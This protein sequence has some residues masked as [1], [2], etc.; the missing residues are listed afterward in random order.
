M[1]RVAGELGEHRTDQLPV[2]HA[3]GLGV[4]GQGAPQGQGVEQHE[5]RRHPVD[6]V[7]VAQAG[8]RAGHGAGQ[9]D[10]QQQAAHHRAHHLAALRHRRQGGGERHQ[11]LGYHGKRPGD[12]RADQQGG[13]GPGG[14]AHQQAGGGEQHH[15]DDQPPALHQVAERHQQDQAQRVA[16]LGHGDDDAGP[17]VGQAE[18]I[19][20]GVQQR[21]RVVV[22]G[23]HQAG[24]GGHQQ[25]QPG[26][27]GGFGG[28]LGV[29]HGASFR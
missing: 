26:A 17:G 23:H 28:A 25:D 29:R 20:D 13:Q 18:L 6:S 10:A 12:G 2:V 4:A 5:R 21:L 11:H 24:G 15:G 1:Q 8:E 9:Q 22:A 19:R 27:Q 14:G 7:P 16:G 3:G